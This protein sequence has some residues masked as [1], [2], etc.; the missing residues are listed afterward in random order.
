MPMCELL[1]CTERVRQP[2][3]VKATT[4]ALTDLIRPPWVAKKNPLHHSMLFLGKTVV[5]CEIK[6]LLK[7]FWPL[8]RSRRKKLFAARDRRTSATV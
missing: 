1:W 3:F 8:S 2:E 6:K 5:T 7:L 4:L